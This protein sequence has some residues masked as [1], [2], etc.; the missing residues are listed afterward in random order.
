MPAMPDFTAYRAWLQNRE[1]SAGTI[2]KYLR[3]TARF[4]RET[5]AP[6][7]PPKAAVAAWRD[8][9]A[10]K[11]YAPMGLLRQT[12][13]SITLYSSFCAFLPQSSP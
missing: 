4:F 8:A 9:L 2:E 12:S 5:G 13:I 3:D 1:R 11:G 10:A 7:P 6:Q